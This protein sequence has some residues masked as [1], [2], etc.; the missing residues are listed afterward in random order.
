MKQQLLA[1]IS[2]L[3]LSTFV[4][5]DVNVGVILG[6]TGPGAS[7]GVPTKNVFSILPDTLGGEK[8]NYI[9]LD[10]G[11]D[12]STAV[13]NAHKLTK[14][15][16]VDL[17]LGPT[18]VPTALAVVSVA[19]ETKTPLIAFSPL[20]GSNAKSSWAFSVPAS[21]SIM[22]KPVVDHMVANGI[23]TVAYIGFSDGLGEII[24]NGFVPQA[25]AAGMKL[26]ASERYGRTDTSVMGQIL[27]II[28]TKPDAVVIGG[29]GTPGALPHITLM[30]KNY[31]G[32]I[33]HS[34][35]VVNKDFIRVGGKQ[36]EGAMAPC[37]PGVVASQLPESNP[38]KKPALQFIN[39]YE[40][41]YGAGSSNMFGGLAWDGYLL[42]DRAVAVAVK[43]AR[44]GTVEFRQALR[45]ALENTKE[46]AGYNAIYNLTPTDHTGVGSRSIVL[47]KVEKGDWMLIR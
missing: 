31:K 15:D 18:S 26:V 35:A 47:T 44:P 8:V 21:L 28:G 29:S 1:A 37:G 17:I 20:P 10:D 27:K 2:A 6:A 7:L 19:T 5:A 36:V 33:Y 30:D 40:A 3:A 45:D 13:K 34:N 4:F 38:M 14:E 46:L 39:A 42:S 22:M 32:L 11:T 23:K 12:P 16:N 41:K 43:K 9:V 25:E 24:Y